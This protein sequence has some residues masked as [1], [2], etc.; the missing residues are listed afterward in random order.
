M[1]S[2]K[3][4]IINALIIESEEKQIFAFRPVA[5]RL[6]Y[7]QIKAADVREIISAFRKIIPEYTPYIDV[8][9]PRFSMF[10]DLFFAAKDVSFDDKEE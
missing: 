9:K 5:E 10:N 4:D 6:G 1:K 3:T 8:S 7:K 2:W